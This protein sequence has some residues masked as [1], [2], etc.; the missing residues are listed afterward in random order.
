[1]TNSPNNLAS[2]RMSATDSHSIETWQRIALA[3]EYDGAAYSGWQRQASPELRTIQSSLERALSQ[4]ADTEITAT[5]A[6]R[7]DAG[8]HA[9][10]QVIHFDSPV[11]RSSKAWT[12][13]VNS[14]L[15]ETIRV[16][17]SQTVDAEFHARFSATARQYFYIIY[18]SQVG[19][20][21]LHNKVTHSRDELNY[22]VMNQAAQALLGEQDFSSFQAAGC[23]SKSPNR[24]V[25]H[26]RVFM[27]GA[28][29]ILDIKA[30]AFLQHMVR[31]IAGALLEIGREEQDSD[32]ISDLLAAKDRTLAGVTASPDGLYLVGIDYPAEFALPAT[33]MQPLFLCA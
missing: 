28:F 33:R 24:F 7:T 20:T 11:D 3:I 21:V 18:C 22:E 9:T 13:G 19:S 17:W 4:V 12:M 10:C 26:A 15:P 16:R 5:C 1:M 27:Q 32:W 29:L 8:V 14:L 6:G 31:N 30:N 2:R 25:E 23:Q